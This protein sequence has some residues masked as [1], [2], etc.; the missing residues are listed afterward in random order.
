VKWVHGESGEGDRSRLIGWTDSHVCKGLFDYF[1]P[2]T[3]TGPGIST[4][5]LTKGACKPARFGDEPLIKQAVIIGVAVLALDISPLLTCPVT[6]QMFKYSG[7]AIGGDIPIL[8]QRHFYIS[9]ET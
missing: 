3:Y 1:P 5:L 6:A 7:G 2:M 9:E 8:R 4:G